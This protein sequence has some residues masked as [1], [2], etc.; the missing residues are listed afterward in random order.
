MRVIPVLD[1]RQGRAVWARRGV[2]E[3]YRPVRSTLAPGEGD[4]LALARAFQGRLGCTEA[5]VADLD[6]I[7]GAAPERSLVKAIS[8]TGIS[9]FVDAGVTTVR[10][11]RSASDAGAARVVVGLET[12]ASFRALEAIV[13]ALGTGRVVFSLDLRAGE[14][15]VARAWSWNGGPLALVREAVQAGVGAVLVLDL[16]RVGTGAG[17][18]LALLSAVRDAHPALEL[19]GGGGVASSRDL[20]RMADAG[21]DAVLVASALHDG[22]L[23]AGSLSRHLNDSR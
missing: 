19:L 13:R 7:G 6:A 8:A 22:R 2:R 18:D 9:L 21:C 1:L 5:Y 14:P 20:D 15:V 10:D 12:L 4:A 16:A 23:D 17:V 3:A 11:A